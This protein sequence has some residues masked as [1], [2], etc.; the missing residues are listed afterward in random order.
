[1]V[2]KVLKYIIEHSYNIIMNGINLN[3]YGITDEDLNMKTMN[4]LYYD[5]EL[6]AVVKTFYIARNDKIV[7]TVNGQVVLVK[8]LT[9]WE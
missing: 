7:K 6:Q 3:D 1:M 5:E 4:D 9:G 2:G 8:T